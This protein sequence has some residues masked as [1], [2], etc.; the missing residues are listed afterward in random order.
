MVKIHTI[1]DLRHNYY[2]DYRPSSQ[3]GTASAIA[4]GRSPQKGELRDPDAIFA[5]KVF[6]I[7]VRTVNKTA[8][9]D[10]RHP[11][12]RYSVIEAILNRNA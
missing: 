3:Y 9:G 1:K 6:A 12:T 8:K 10:N 4:L 7:R 2:Q 11:A 5:N